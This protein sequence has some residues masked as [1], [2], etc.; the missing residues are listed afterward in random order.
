[1]TTIAAPSAPPLCASIVSVL[2]MLHGGTPGFLRV[3]ARTE[4]GLGEREIRIPS[5]ERGQLPPTVCELLEDGRWHLRVSPAVRDDGGALR[6]VHVLYARWVIALEFNQ[7][8]SWQHAAPADVVSTIRQ[9]LTAFRYAPSAVIDGLHDVVALWALRAP[10]DVSTKAGYD[11]AIEVQ[12]RLA[13]A[14]D[15]STAVRDDRAAHDPASLIPLA[16]IVR[17]VGANPPVVTL[18][19]NPNVPTYELE[20]I[21]DAIKL[22]KRTS[23][24]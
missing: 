23:K 18:E 8:T 3:T 6:R 14:V 13:A 21:E 20:Q 9:R 5:I 2:E 17:D 19:L 16:G 11:A 10:L 15:A 1:M 22:F 7:Q 4:Q 24:S 12:A